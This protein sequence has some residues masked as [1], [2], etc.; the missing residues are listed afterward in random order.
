MSYTTLLLDLDHTLF[1]S[2]ACEIAAFEDTLGAA[3]VDL[4]LRH[5]DTYFEINAALWTSV[6][7]GAMT[8]QEVRLVRFE[9]LVAKI[10][11]DVDP[12]PL[13]DAFAVGL[14]ANGDLYPGAREALEQLTEHA[15]LALVTNGLSQVQRARVE[16]L[17]LE[18]Y[19]DAILISAELGVAKPAR[20]MFDA[21]FVALDS[22]EKESALMV[23]DSL[24][25]DIR[26]GADYGIATCWYNPHRKTAA[27]DVGVSHEITSLDQLPALVLRG[28]A[29]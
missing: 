3:G 18:H 13:A 2:A 15:R 7:R 14:G 1:D 16:R 11:L 19:F 8:P 5:F 21:A 24:T 27:P 6:E 17:D 12:E 23:G 22:P 25:S 20:E 10:G 29:Q 9:R 4:P 28:R 26:G